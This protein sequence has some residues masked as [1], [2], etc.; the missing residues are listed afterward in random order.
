MVQS[1]SRDSVMQKDSHYISF[2]GIVACFT[3]N[4]TA[5]II[6]KPVVCSRTDAAVMKSIW[7]LLSS[8]FSND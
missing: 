1:F 5:I 3:A 6:H 2:L 4:T 7:P 8:S